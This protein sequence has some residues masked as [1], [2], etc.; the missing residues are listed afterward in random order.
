MKCH[1]VSSHIFVIEIV[2]L[3]KL[4]IRFLFL[5]KKKDRSNVFFQTILSKNVSTRVSAV[6]TS[7]KEIPYRRP[8][9]SSLSPR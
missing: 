4:C 5:R 8:L 6:T 3:P 2:P 1:Q 7:A 9:E